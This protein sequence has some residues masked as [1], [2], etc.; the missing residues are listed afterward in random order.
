MS[1]R[2]SI[3]DKMMDKVVEKEKKLREYYIAVAGAEVAKEES[4]DR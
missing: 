3:G 1:V 4:G 2:W